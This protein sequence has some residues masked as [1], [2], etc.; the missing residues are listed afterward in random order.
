MAPI[1]YPGERKNRIPESNNQR[2]WALRPTVNSV[3][4]GWPQGR[5]G[6]VGFESS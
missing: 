4:R 6:C 2:R 3:H 5:T 1:R